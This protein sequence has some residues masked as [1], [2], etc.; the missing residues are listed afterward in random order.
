MFFVRYSMALSPLFTYLDV[1]KV[2]LSEKVLLHWNFSFSPMNFFS[3]FFLVYRRSRRHRCGVNRQELLDHL[4]GKKNMFSFCCFTI[5]VL[6][7]F[8]RLVLRR[9]L[10]CEWREQYMC[11]TS[12]G[13]SIFFYCPP[14]G[15]FSRCY[16]K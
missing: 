11:R 14:L 12:R 6:S 9:R 2:L 1:S 5:K 7:F 3:L 8:F 13:Y 10:L 15:N 16:G 4:K